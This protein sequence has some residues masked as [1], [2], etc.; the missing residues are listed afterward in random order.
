[1]KDFSA[2]SSQVRIQNEDFDVG[3]D[4]ARMRES[5]PRTGALASFLGVVRDINDDRDV[6]GMHLE[7]YP[8]MTEKAILRIV[9]EA[10][11][12][13]DLHEVTVI[14]RVG[15]LVPTD[16]IVLVAVGSAHRGEAFAACEYIMD[17]LKTRAPFWKRESGSLGA[18]WVKARVTD[19]EAASRWEE[20]ASA[21]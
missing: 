21:T 19:D 9:A 10:G 7:Y 16:Q 8:G 2:M 17:F 11:A 14:H 12:R 5:S 3:V 6:G 13:W 18:R 15:D 4:L 20:D 1:M